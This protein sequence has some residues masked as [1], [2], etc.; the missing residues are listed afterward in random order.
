MSNNAENPGKGTSETTWYTIIHMAHTWSWCICFQT[1]DFFLYYYSKFPF[2]EQHNQTTEELT[3]VFAEIVGEYRFPKGI[4]SYAGSNFVISDFKAFCSALDNETVATSSYHQVAN[5]L[6]EWYIQTIKHIS[7]KFSME[8][9]NL[10]IALL[11]I[12]TSP[13]A[14]NLPWLAELL[15]RKISC[16]ISV[17]YLIFYRLW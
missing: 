11:S 1:T 17:I 6:V 16:L 5:G 10:S 9:C 4:V 14:P 13:L 3:Q 7:R 15:G 12:C 2:H 8:N